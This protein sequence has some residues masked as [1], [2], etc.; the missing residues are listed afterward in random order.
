MW[1]WIVVA[2]VAVIHAA[3]ISDE[4][5]RR[6]RNAKEEIFRQV[7][8][9]L[10]CIEEKKKREVDRQLFSSSSFIFCQIL[11]ARDGI[12]RMEYL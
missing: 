4:E 6:I 1:L 9:N 3:V 10:I 11:P 8:E 12:P 7:F 2:V 5:N